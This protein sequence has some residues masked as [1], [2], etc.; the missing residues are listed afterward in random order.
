[1]S[2]DLIKACKSGDIKKVKYLIDKGADIHADYDHALRLATYYGHLEVVKYLVKKGS[3]IHTYN[4]EALRLAV[5]YDHL[6]IILYLKSIY[7]KRYKEKFL[8][9]NCIILPCC[10]LLCD[11]KILK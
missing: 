7:C 10:K 11:I 9:Y 2:N 3:Y 5:K 8:C 6:E 4:N 1:M